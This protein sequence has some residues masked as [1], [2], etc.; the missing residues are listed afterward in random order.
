MNLSLHEAI[1][2]AQGKAAGVFPVDLARVLCSVTLSDWELVR[3]VDAPNPDDFINQL[4][5][6]GKSLIFPDKA[7]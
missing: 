3:W 5:Q 7:S 1:T 4:G 6:L 2:G